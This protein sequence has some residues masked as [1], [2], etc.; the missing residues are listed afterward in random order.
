MLRYAQ[1]KLAT[2]NFSLI[3]KTKISA[4]YCIVFDNYGTIT[5]ITLIASE[6]NKIDT[7]FHV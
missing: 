5:K 1:N 2:V 4:I 7:I 6:N 3:R